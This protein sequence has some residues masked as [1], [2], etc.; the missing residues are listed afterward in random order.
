[1][2]D[3][4][5]R[6][7]LIALKKQPTTKHWK[8]WFQD[9]FRELPIWRVPVD[10]LALN[11]DNRRFRAERMWVEERLGRSL[12]PENNPHDESS[13]E[14]LLLDSQH[15]VEGDR[16]IGKP[17]DDYQSLKRDWLH[18]TQESPLWI[19]P[20]GTVR[21]GNRRLAMIKRLQIDEGEAGLQW[22]EAVILTLEEVD[23]P[24]LLE[25]EQREQLTENFKIRY[26]DIDYLLA[27]KEMAEIRIVDWFDRDSIEQVAGTLQSM[28][29]QS[30][31]E[32]VRDL[33]AIKY[34]DLFLEDSGQTGKYHVLLRTLEKFRDIGRTM[35]K[36]ETDY[37]LEADRILQ[38]LFA[39]VR[40]KRP[41]GEIRAIRRMFRLD[42][43]RFTQLADRID[44]AEQRSP[45][46]AGPMLAAP[47]YTGSI[48][49]D[50]E[51]S[52]G[53]E[54][55]SSGPEA[56]DYPRSEVSAA[57]TLAI[58][59]FEASRQADVLKILQEIVNRVDV[60]ESGSRL[61]DS[62]NS[63]SSEALEIKAELVKIYEWF[64][65]RR[66]MIFNSE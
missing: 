50:E 24:T 66:S 45:L 52:E 3:P 23:E 60:L 61:V 49:E 20:D 34:M 51:D 47:D 4:L 27:L 65:Q 21:N 7:E 16:I 11:V 14:S 19:R 18:R 6:E 57:I 12:D 56:E 9:Q 31:P 32:I 28:V 44:A 5:E 29:E 17:T 33:Y 40:A 15:Q 46:D 1:M 58:D 2:R 59:G 43:E 64:D 8:L 41:H 37:P 55:D 53:F 26:D 38:V 48:S 22:V 10:A 54:E 30:Q 35:M 62:I 13:I 63:S 39:A 25:M 42:R 36:V